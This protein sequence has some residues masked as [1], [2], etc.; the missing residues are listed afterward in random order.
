MKDSVK[1]NPCIQL[2]Y[3]FLTSFIEATEP[4]LKNTE[5]TFYKRV[6]EDIDFNDHPINIDKYIDFGTDEICKVA[7][8]NIENQ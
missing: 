7:I 4:Y 8:K 6:I 2:G 3:K 1:N 5:Y